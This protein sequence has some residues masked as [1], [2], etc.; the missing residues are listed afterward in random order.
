MLIKSITY[1]GFTGGTYTED[2]YFNL[3]QQEL[4][5]AELSEH[6]GLSARLK[7]IVAAQDAPAIAREFDEIIDLAYGVVSPDGKRFIKSPELTAAFKQTLAY[8]QLYSKLV[9]DDAEAAAFIKGIM[10]EVDEEA[11]E[12]AKAEMGITAI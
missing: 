7:K 12:K 3:T 1:P 6:G 10:P 4:I 5:H 11:L 8:D 2:F 9:S